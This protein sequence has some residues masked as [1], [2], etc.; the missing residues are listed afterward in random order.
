MFNIYIVLVAA[1]FQASF[2]CAIS[3]EVANSISSPED[4]VS[5]LIMDTRSFKDQMPREYDIEARRRSAIDKNFIRFGRRDMAIPLHNTLDLEY[6]D[7]LDE[8]SRANRARVDKNDNF[9]RFGRGK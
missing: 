9:I 7:Y 5:Y 2:T 4:G 8:F 3:E 6:E 1:L